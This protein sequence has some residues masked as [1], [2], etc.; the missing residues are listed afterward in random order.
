MKRLFIL[1]ASLSFTTPAYGL[2][3]RVGAFF[4]PTE[5]SDPDLAL[6][7]TLALTG[8][9]VS[10]SGE[11][12]VPYD[13]MARALDYV[14]LQNPGDCVRS[15]ICL[16]NVHTEMKLSVLVI[17]TWT[18][19]DNQR[20]RIELERVHKDPLLRFTRTR[21][22]PNEPLKIAQNLTEMAQEMVNPPSSILV[23]SGSG[24]I[25]V[26][27]DGTVVGI[28]PGTFVLTPGRRN[29]VLRQSGREVLNSQIACPIGLT[30]SAEVPG[31]LPNQGPAQVGAGSTKPNYIIP[32]KEPTP[33]LRYGGF[34]LTA[35]GAGLII[36][37]ALEA[38][39]M[40]DVEDQIND[41]C[42]TVDGHTI[43]SGLSQIGFEALQR[44]GEDHASLSN[45]YLLTGGVLTLAGI[46]IALYDIFASSTPETQ[47]S[48]DT[49][50]RNFSAFRLD[51]GHGA[52]WIR[53]RIDF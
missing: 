52:T 35:V 13:E 12:A 37:A 48:L 20:V 38:Q 34:S 47:T 22:I 42:D 36:F 11:K 14:S 53:H 28:G 23:V 19:L 45:T 43:C 5:G 41:T 33:W 29:I 8:A 51:F 15:E 7:M 40:T 18:D 44:Q 31:E 26:E 1:I 32:M 16:A 27:I 25:E 21:E 9:L 6:D 30:C 46:G 39:K 2:N 24:S 10:A 49:T 3:D 50:S 4:V 17:G